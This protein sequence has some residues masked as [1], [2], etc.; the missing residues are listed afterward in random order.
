MTTPYPLIL[1]ASGLTGTEIVKMLTAAK[2]NVRVSYRE[3][4]EL[5][6]LRNFGAEPIFA[7]FADLDSLRQSMID[8][9]SAALILPINQ[10]MSEWGKNVIDCA[11]EAKL[12]KLVLLS[13]LSANGDAA[14]NIPRM[15]GEIIEHLKQSGVPYYIVQ[16]APYFQNIF[17]SVIT[18]VRHHQFSLPLGNTELPYIDLRDVAVFMS[19]LLCEEHPAGQTFRITGATAFSM[20]RVARRL[21][22]ALEQDVRY[23]PTPSANAEHIFRTMG[24]TSWLAK[25]IAEMY[26]EYESGEYSVPT[27]DFKR[28]TGRAPTGLDKF[29]ERNIMVFRQDTLPEHLLSEG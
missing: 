25:T 2:I 10:K 11:K 14:S 18:I 29:I 27:G 13:N 16:S 23:T 21:S 19:K 17:W 5:N 4:S 24:M 1:G 15:H 22:Q 3:Q 12:P 8:V 26:A 7:D 9:T 6:V 28:I 20:F